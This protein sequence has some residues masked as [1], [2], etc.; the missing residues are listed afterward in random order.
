MEEGIIPFE[1]AAKM[2]KIAGF[3]NILV[4]DYLEI[5]HKMVFNSLSDLND[6]KVFAE[7]VYKL[8]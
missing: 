7:N 6:F 5:D 2:K 4:H 1:L 8:L 3:R